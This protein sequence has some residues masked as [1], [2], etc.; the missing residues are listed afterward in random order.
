MGVTREGKGVRLPPLKFELSFICIGFSL[1]NDVR[2]SVWPPSGKGG[3]PWTIFWLHPCFLLCY[4]IC[5]WCLKSFAH[6]Y[7]Y[8]P[9]V[10]LQHSSMCYWVH[11]WVLHH[12]PMVLQG[13]FHS[14]LCLLP[15]SWCLVSS[16][17]SLSCCPLLW[18]RIPGNCVIYIRR[19]LLLVGSWHHHVMSG[20]TKISYFG[21][22][23]E[24]C[25]TCGRHFTL[26]DT[27]RA[28]VLNLLS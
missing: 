5:L 15:D 13:V 24:Y 17:H 10:G 12:E 18:L 19:I 20:W 21:H 7:S 26:I 8:L 16:V 28:R 14:H 4:S 2:A 9:T 27:W 11:I 1:I 6:F 3:P 25:I 23:E 22:T